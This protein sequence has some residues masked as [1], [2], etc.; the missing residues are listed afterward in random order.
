MGWAT[1]SALSSDSAPATR[2]A[3]HG[4]WPGEDAEEAEVRSVH[5]VLEALKAGYLYRREPMCLPELSLPDVMSLH[6]P[7]APDNSW[8]IPVLPTHGQAANPGC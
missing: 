8:G 7:L 5:W 1:G 6:I 3:G 4:R 2:P